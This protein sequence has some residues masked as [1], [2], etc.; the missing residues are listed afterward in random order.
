VPLNV[1]DDGVDVL[2]CGG[3]KW[4]LGAPGTGFMYVKK[5]VQHLI[6]PV[7]PGMWAAEISFTD[8]R[9]HDDARRYETGTLAD[10]L[11]Y[12]WTGG[13][14]LLLELG[15]DKIHARVLELTR[16]FIDGLSGKNV[17]IVSPV[18]RTD[19]RSA[20]VLISAGDSEANRTLYKKLRSNNIVVSLR[21]EVI[22]VSPNFFNTEAD[23]DVLL[24]QL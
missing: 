4:L 10:S 14:E 7:I 22:R 5:D 18:E 9:F 23:I 24:K 16:Y 20:I 12:A 21:S 3:F 17:T 1:I 15:V 13:L 11:F 2:C 19:E 8:L 6:S